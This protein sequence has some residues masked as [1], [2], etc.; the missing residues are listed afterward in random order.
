L[1]RDLHDGAQQQLVSM[2]LDLGLT[3]DHLAS[4][5]TEEATRLLEMVE[6]QLKHAIAD[7]RKLARGLHPG[8]LTRSGLQAAIEA[9]IIRA[10]FPVDL[11]VDPGPRPPD[12]MEAAAYFVVAESLT[13]ATRHAQA[14]RMQ[15]ELRRNDG[16]LGVSIADDG[17]GGAS[18]DSGTGLI[19]LR[20]RVT[21]LGGEFMLE[22]PP[23]SGTRLQVQL[24]LDGAR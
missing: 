2:G 3:Q 6:A 1:E 21:A 13:N 22:S 20:D 17:Q 15:V 11:S 4:G 23:G 14:G 8:I 10:P 24:P 18:M 9:L 12:A 5:E 7:L 19:G 16:W